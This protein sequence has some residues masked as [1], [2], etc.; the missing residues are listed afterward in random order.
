MIIDLNWETNNHEKAG[1]GATVKP[2]RN[3]AKTKGT[4]GPPPLQ[5]LLNYK[6][7]GEIRN[8]SPHNGDAATEGGGPQ[9]PKLWHLNPQ[10]IKKQ[11]IST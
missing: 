9:K 2:Q 5:G 4:K 3:K 6:I 8:R 11:F 1:T 10:N 7:T